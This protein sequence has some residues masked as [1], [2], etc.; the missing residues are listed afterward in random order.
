MTDHMDGS[1]AG[2]ANAGAQESGNSG[3]N[4]EAQTVEQLL[5]RIEALEGHQKTAQSGKDRGINQLEQKVDGQ[6]AEISQ[7]LAKFPDPAD[8]K[9]NYEIDQFLKTNAQGQDGTAG[10]GVGSGTDVQAGQQVP[11]DTSANL[12]EGLGVDNQSAEFK[13]AIAA[14]QSPEQAALNILAA[15]QANAS[16]DDGNA[17]GISGSGSGQGLTGTAQEALAQQ[18]TKELDAQPHWTPFQLQNLNDKY[19]KLG[20]NVE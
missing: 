19:R 2:N 7:Y 18:R 3:V 20:L 6:F 5:A 10:T 11:G 8:A 12:L 17:S 16:N 13:Q 15:R 14:G 1:G 9:R 4:S